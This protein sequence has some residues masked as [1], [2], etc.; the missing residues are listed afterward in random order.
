MKY[1]IFLLLVLFLFGCTGFEVGPSIV[2]CEADFNCFINS[3]ERCEPVIY[4]F[5]IQNAGGNR[6]TITPTDDT[7]V[8]EGIY[9][10][11]DGKRIQSNVIVLRKPI[12]KCSWDSLGKTHNGYLDVE[13]KCR[14]IT[15]NIFS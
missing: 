3:L 10:N 11:Y 9:Y 1:L 8:Y 2:D 7:C 14:I 15:Q 12:E 6:K 4:D 13:N 5:S